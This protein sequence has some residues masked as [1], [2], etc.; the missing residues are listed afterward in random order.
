M[1]EPWPTSASRKRRFA[2]F[3]LP[4]RAN[5]SATT[6]EETEIPRREWESPRWIRRY[7][8]PPSRDAALSAS[9]RTDPRATTA[10]AVAGCS[11]FQLSGSARATSQPVRPCV[12]VSISDHRPRVEDPVDLVRGE[13]PFFRNQFPDRL[14]RVVRLVGKLRGLVITDPHRERGHH[15]QALLDQFGAPRPVRRDPGD[16]P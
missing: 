5:S 2:S 10:V 16:A 14:P 12:T 15:R 4:K 9:G 6:S 13:P 7:S 11:P 8:S 3:H 1:W